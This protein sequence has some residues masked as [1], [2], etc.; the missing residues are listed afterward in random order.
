MD[1]QTNKPES[2]STRPIWNP[3]SEENGRT[4]KQL[5]GQVQST[6]EGAAQNL[7]RARVARSGGQGF[8][9]APRDE[10]E[11]ARLQAACKCASADAAQVAAAVEL[12]SGLSLGQG[13]TTEGR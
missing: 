4:L 10:N 3:A 5:A 6:T 13:N 2:T 11:M 8:F 7:E 9:T 12:H 1:T